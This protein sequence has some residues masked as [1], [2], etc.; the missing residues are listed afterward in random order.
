MKAAALVPRGVWIAE[1]VLGAIVV[2]LALAW[3]P[4]TCE[5]GTDKYIVAGLAAL[6]VAFGIPVAMA[7]LKVCQRLALGIGFALAILGVWVLGWAL[8][9]FRFLCRLW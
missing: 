7:P 6:P 4:R 8:G 2:A 5:G 1:L 9:E 3:G